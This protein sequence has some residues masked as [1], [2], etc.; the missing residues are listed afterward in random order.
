PRPEHATATAR[1]RAHAKRTAREPGRDT[2]SDE[3]SG[4]AS[5]SHLA[6]EWNGSRMGPHFEF[7]LGRSA[8][9]PSGGRCKEASGGDSVI[10][11]GPALLTM[12]ELYCLR[13]P[14]SAPGDPAAVHR[15]SRRRRSPDR[16]AV[17]MA[18]R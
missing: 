13:T 18:D 4:A 10:G 9:G 11:T 3:N 2:T 15:S 7:V 16:S 12:T 5:M 14:P 6:R 8:P 1:R 17:H